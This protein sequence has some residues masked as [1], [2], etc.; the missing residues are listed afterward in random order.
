MSSRRPTPST[1]AC[2]RRA[3][4]VRAAAAGLL[5]LAA[6]LLVSCGGSSDKLIPVANAGPLQSDFETVAQDAEAGNGNCSVTERAILETEQDFDALPAAVD[7]GLRETLRQ[8][9]ENLHARALVL[10]AQPL[11]QS[12]LTSTASKTTASTPT[13]TTTTT[14]TATTPPSTTPDTT[15]TSTTPA[16]GTS[17]PGTGESSAGVPSGPG[18]GTGAGESGAPS[19]AGTP[20]NGS[21]APGNGAAGQENGK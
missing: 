21:G 12:T 19:G 17:A 5:G 16:G 3:W 14:T 11:V 1:R 13:T 15:P 4:I 10:C 7:A 6:A 18:G 9:I 20:E 8:G 2:S